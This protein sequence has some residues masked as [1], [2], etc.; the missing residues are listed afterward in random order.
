MVLALWLLLLSHKGG[1]PRQAEYAVRWDP[2]KGGLSSAEQTLAFLGAAG[3]R[4]ED[5]DVR[6]YDL[7]A[8][9]ETPPDSTVILRRRAVTDGRSEIRLKFR[10]LRPLSG[11][12]ACP[13]SFRAK[14]EVDIGFGADAPARVYSYSC[15]LA[16][17]EPPAALR[18][19]PKPCASKV[20]RYAVQA[21]DGQ[22]Y[23]VEVWTLP[24]GAARIEISRSA[25]NTVE[26]LARFTALVERLR[27]RGV[28][29]IE[30]SKTELGSRC[31]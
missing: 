31:P 21:P 22:G 18:A 28:H 12:W 8:P 13:A 11:R 14:D 16:A 19:S 23:K 17:D 7:P 25:D 10:R 3:A 26:A 29:A 9:P 27:A 6:Y 5:S 2:A 1:E 15:V 24:D 20:A 4:R 30:E